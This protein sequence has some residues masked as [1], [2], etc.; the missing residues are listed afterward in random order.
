MIAVIVPVHDEEALLDGC[1]AAVARAAADDRLFSE[2]VG[3]FVALD[4]CRDRSAEIAM[5]HGATC[6]PVQA[7]N[8]GVARRSAAAAALAAG[9]RWIASTDADSQVPAR[10]LSMQLA[11]AS[12]AV[13]G[14]V[15]VADWLDHAPAVQARYR[16]RYAP[17]DGHRHVHGANLGVSAEAYLRCGGFPEQATGEDVALV[18][19]LAEAACRI[20]W[21]A[22]PCV[23]TSARRD[24]R[25][26]DGFGHYLA[27]L[28]SSCA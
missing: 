14:T 2:P 18:R 1:L 9:A 21:T 22:S 17:A 16:L 3:V 7:R 24:A 8:V 5:R 15:R 26:P 20:A 23:V 6:I 28:K 12:D 19:R 11:H 10:W 13:C 4:A 27:T 25:A